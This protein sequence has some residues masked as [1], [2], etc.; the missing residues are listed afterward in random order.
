MDVDPEPGVNTVS[1][2]VI[3]DKCVIEALIDLGP[4]GQFGHGLIR[5]P[6][7]KGA[8]YGWDYLEP[9]RASNWTYAPSPKVNKDVGGVAYHWPTVGQKIHGLLVWYAFA[10][11]TE[12]FP[13]PVAY[14][15]VCRCWLPISNWDVS[16]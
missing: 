1:R 7:Y 5:P 3:D 11:P 4:E 2:I 10:P 8:K 13:K 9:T 14:W 16:R 15:G 6:A 12:D